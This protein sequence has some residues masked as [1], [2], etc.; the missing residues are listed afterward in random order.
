MAFT[1]AQK[2]MQAA[3][4]A[5]A[6]ASAIAGGAAAGAAAGPAAPILIP[7]L[8]AGALAAVTAAVS[9]YAIQQQIG[10]SGNQSKMENALEQLVS[11][12]TQNNR[13]QENQNFT[14]GRGKLKFGLEGGLGG[15]DL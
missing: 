12:Q 14:I 5:S 1:I 10:G 15:R 11:L 8:I 7:L 2:A 3:S 4:I 13:N 6:G 9:S